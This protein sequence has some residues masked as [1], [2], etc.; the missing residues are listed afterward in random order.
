MKPSSSTRTEIRLLTQVIRETFHEIPCQAENDVLVLD[1][2]GTFT[3]KLLKFLASKKNSK[4]EYPIRN[5]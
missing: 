2:N 3:K 1:D 5:T 4:F